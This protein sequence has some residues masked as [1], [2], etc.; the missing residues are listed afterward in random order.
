M[1]TA[2]ALEMLGEAVIRTLHPEFAEHPTLPPR[3]NF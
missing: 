3:T 1:L 2:T